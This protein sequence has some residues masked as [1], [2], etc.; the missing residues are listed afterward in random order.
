MFRGISRTFGRNCDVA[1]VTVVGI[2]TA[3]HSDSAA[4][5]T[6]GLAVG[7]DSSAGRYGGDSS[8]RLVCEKS[9]VAGEEERVAMRQWPMCYR[10]ETTQ[11]TRRRLTL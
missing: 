2:T 9:D 8:Q 4:R 10:Q 6:S 7:I 5:C 1:V 3:V 11:P